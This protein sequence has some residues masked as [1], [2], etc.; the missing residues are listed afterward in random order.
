MHIGE[1]FSNY[2]KRRAFRKRPDCWRSSSFLLHRWR[3]DW[4]SATNLRSA[5]FLSGLLAFLRSN[6]EKA[7]MAK[8]HRRLQRTNDVHDLI[9]LRSHPTSSALS[10]RLRTPSMPSRAF[11]C[12][13]QTHRS[14]R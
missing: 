7:A 1:P 6:S 8:G 11:S 3:N 5:I 4:D 12:G 9:P 14:G 2:L 10:Q 13:N